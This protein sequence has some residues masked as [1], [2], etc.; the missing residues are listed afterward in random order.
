MTFAEVAAIENARA[1][2][3]WGDDE[4]PGRNAGLTRAIVNA[5]LDGPKDAETVAE[6][7]GRDLRKV[8]S[9]LSRNVASGRL[10]VDKSVRPYRYS[11][12]S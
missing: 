3:T 9:L 2:L 5:L 10:S 1:R 6:A 8:R 7:I 11:V 12:R 4:A